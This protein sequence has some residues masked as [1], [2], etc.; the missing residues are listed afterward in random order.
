M[1]TFDK[2]WQGDHHDVR[3]NVDDVNNGTATGDL[4]LSTIASF[5]YAIGVHGADAF[6]NRTYTKDSVLDGGNA[7]GTVVIPIVGADTA[8]CQ[9]GYCL[10]QIWMTDTDGREYTVFEQSFEM[11]EKLKL[12]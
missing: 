11:R 5:T 7:G 12:S 1:R 8:L 3:L 2:L 10:L 6:C 9:P 4:N